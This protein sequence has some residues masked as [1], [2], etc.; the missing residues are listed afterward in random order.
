MLNEDGADR[1]VSEVVE[2]FLKLFN[3]RWENDRPEHYCCLDS[4]RRPCHTS[5]AAARRD[6]FDALSELILCA[7]LARMSES[8]KKWSE[9][10]RRACLL[11]FLCRCHHFM[12]VGSMAWLPRRDLLELHRLRGYDGAGRG[13]R[14]QQARGR[15]ARAKARAF[16]RGRRGRGGRGRGGGA[17]PP[18][19]ARAE[20]D[21]LS[22]ERAADDP[23]VKRKKRQAKAGAFWQSPASI[24]C[25]LAL[26]VVSSPSRRLLASMFQTEQAA[27]IAAAGG[28]AAEA[29]MENERKKGLSLSARFSLCGRLVRDGGSVDKASAT[30]EENLVADVSALSSTALFSLPGAL[31]RNRAYALNAFAAHWYRVVRRMKK[32]NSVYGLVHAFEADPD[33]DRTVDNYK[34]CFQEKQCCDDP[35]LFRRWKRRKYRDARGDVD[36]GNM[37]ALQTAVTRLANAPMICS[38]VKLEVC[39]GELNNMLSKKH[40]WKMGPKPLFGDQILKNFRASLPMYQTL[41][42]KTGAPSKKLNQFSAEQRSG[43][44]VLKT[45]RFVK[46]A[47]RSLARARVDQKS[48]GQARCKRR[49]IFQVYVD[50]EKEKLQIAQP[51]HVFQRGEFFAWKKRTR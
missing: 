16:L 50:E 35:W 39:H 6:L 25:T 4:S 45:A 10:P 23:H 11:G 47:F 8:T 22:P 48:A 43:K 30:L 33:P 17:A 36:L 37:K 29:L 7:L 38:I 46:T 9:L 20:R 12:R 44:I 31:L 15:G 34:N 18:R 3:G 32:K 24:Q 5:V 14:G 28:A 2:R 27:G 26:A 49:F 21:S 41:R 40:W 42:L 19:P 13:A 1:D 51:G